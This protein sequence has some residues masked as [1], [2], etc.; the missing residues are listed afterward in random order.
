MGFSL[1]RGAG[2]MPAPSLAS[3]RVVLVLLRAYAATSVLRG[4]PRGRLRATTVPD[5]NS[6]PP[7]TP[8]G[9]RRSYAPARHCDR[10]GHSWHSDL[11]SSTSAGDSANQSSG[12]VRHGIAASVTTARS[13]TL[14]SITMVTSLRVSVRTGQTKRPRTRVS[15]SAAWKAPVCVELDRW[16]PGTNPELGLAVVDG[17]RRGGH[18]ARRDGDLRTHC[19]R[20][21][22]GGGC[23]EALLDALDA[24][25]AGTGSHRRDEP[26]AVMHPVG[27]GCLHWC[28]LSS[29]LARATLI[30]RQQHTR[31]RA[32]K[33]QCI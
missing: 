17:R 11:A 4:R 32:G 28:L 24:E 16:T 31:P 25:R 22:D 18:G 26:T 14:A 7:Q 23:N 15:G 9:S 13:R 5:T 3:P 19:S 8:Q 6:S 12:S 1:R 10:T 27:V 20:R 30:G 29:S 21:R 2:L 33:E